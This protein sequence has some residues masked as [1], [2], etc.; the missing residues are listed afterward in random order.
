APLLLVKPRPLSAA[1]KVL[2]AV[3]PVHEHDKPAE[4]DRAILSFAKEFNTAV[5]GELHVLHS[6]DTA[7]TLAVATDTPMA[8]IAVPVAELTAGI[9]NEHRN[10]LESL[11][12]SYPVEPTN[13]H[14]E[15]G[16]AHD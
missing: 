6:F 5:Q 2:A 13:V 10:A 1:P 16:V 14:L 15:E 11:L 7:A 8:T 3:D 4:L 9:E 12:T